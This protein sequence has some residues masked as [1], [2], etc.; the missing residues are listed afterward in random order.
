M[1]APNFNFDLGPGP[2]ILALVYTMIG[3]WVSACALFL[4]NVYLTFAK[5]RGVSIIVNMQ[6]LSLY[7]TLAVVFFMFCNSFAVSDELFFAMVLLIPLMV[8]SHFIC[9]LVSARRRK[10]QFENR[11]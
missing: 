10:R 1:F 4:F 6:V 3:L 11:T 9:L 5:S 8:I 7:T 2:W